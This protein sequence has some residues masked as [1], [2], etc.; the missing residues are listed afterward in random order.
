MVA[1][2]AL[3]P[4][5]RYSLARTRAG[6][7][8]VVA[9]T[10]LLDGAKVDPA[11]LSHAIQTL[12]AKYALLSCSVAN[13]ATGEPHFRRSAVEARDVLV[14]GPEV[15]RDAGDALLA[16][17]G[18]G[19]EFDVEKAPLWRVWHSAAGAQGQIRLTLAVHH[20]L[21]DGTSTRNIFAHLLRAL[22]EP[23]TGD[24]PV[25][26]ELAPSLEDTVD[27]RP[28]MLT[29]V[30]T[31]VEELVLLKLP[32]FL[33]P[34]PSPV[35]FPNPPLLSPYLQPTALKVLSLPAPVVARLKATAK[36]RDIAT[37]HPVLYTAAL[38]ALSSSL[39]ARDAAS[40]ADEI[41]G[42]S[43]ISL[44][45]PSAGHPAITGNYVCSLSTAHGPAAPSATAFWASC[46]AYATRLA[47]PAARADA[48]GG[49]GLLAYVPNG[50][51][52]SGGAQ[53]ART[54]FDVWM[55]EKLHSE[56]PYGASFEVSNLGVLPPTGWEGEGGIDEVYWAQAAMAVGPALAINPIAVR[57]G[58]L[59]IT[60]TYRAGTV[61]EATVAAFWRSFE[62]VLRRLAEGNDADGATF[63]DL[64]SE[65]EWVGRMPAP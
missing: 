20:V 8:P 37:L 23:P 50:A 25:E 53:D 9:V 49:M 3:G 31:V 63:K 15:G 35:V 45:D 43:P 4:Y 62:R 13:A 1:E 7:A 18:A 42:D 19:V 57:G 6:V 39:S 48:K 60:L 41:V 17:L 52:G 29:L 65:A 12:L 26:A 38:A 16:A 21:S 34:A 58:N 46:A 51:A 33:R 64:A 24:E 56:R 10:A 44:R 59:A 30:K 32:S 40:R 54:G 22:R 47:D 55:E 14:E 36:A 11:R 5:E 61:E 2:R 27:V 28:S